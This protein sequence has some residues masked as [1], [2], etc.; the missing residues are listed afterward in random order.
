MEY[1]ANQIANMAN[2]LRLDVIEMTAAANSGHP[3]GSLSAADFMAALYFRILRHDPANPQWE[4]RDRFVLSKGH[5]APVLYA[6]LAESGYFPKDIRS[7]ERFPAWR[8][9]RDPSVRVSACHAGSHL[10]ENATGRTTG[11]TVFSETENFRA[12]RTGKLRRSP[13]TTDSAIS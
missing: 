2:I 12:A 3:G 13:T 10:P 6:A 5:V 7:A 9:P 1:S 11:R 8:C 4:D